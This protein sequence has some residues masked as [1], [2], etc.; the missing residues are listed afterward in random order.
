MKKSLKTPYKIGLTGGIGSGKS[1]ISEIFKSLGVGVYNSD[2]ISKHILLQNTEIQKIK[3]SGD[4]P[5]N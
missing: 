3:T 5:L 1:T 4:F 2:K